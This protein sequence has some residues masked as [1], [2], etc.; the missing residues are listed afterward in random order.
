MK[1]DL[2]QLQRIERSYL[3]DEVTLSSLKQMVLNVLNYNDSSFKMAPN[4]IITAIET[5]TELRILLL[6]ENSNPPVQQLNS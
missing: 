6:D 1:I 4:N 2:K 3:H 5:L